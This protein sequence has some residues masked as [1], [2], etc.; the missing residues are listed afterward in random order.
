MTTEVT[1][2]STQK[3][4]PDLRAYCSENFLIIST[5]LSDGSTERTNNRLLNLCNNYPYNWRGEKQ[6]CCNKIKNIRCNLNNQNIQKN[7]NSAKQKK[8]KSPCTG[9]K[10]Q[11]ILSELTSIKLI[12][13]MLVKISCVYFSVL[14]DTF[15]AETE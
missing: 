14:Y 8:L 6:E 5:D 15:I 1:P 11:V 3:Y 4:V 13:N 12:C 9:C 7:K 2:L 10:T